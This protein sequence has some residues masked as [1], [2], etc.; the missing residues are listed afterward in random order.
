MAAVTLADGRVVAMTALRLGDEVVSAPGGATSPI[1]LFSH[2]VVGGEHDFVRVAAEP[3]AAGAGGR[4]LTLSPGH[5]VYAV[6]AG[7]VA[8]TAA[9]RL[10][11]AAALVVGDTLRDA[12][13]DALAVT[14]VTPVRGVGLYNPHTVSGDLIVDG[15]HVS[16]LTTAVAPAVARSLLAPLAWAWRVGVSRSGLGG[17][18]HASV[19]AAVLALLPTGESHVEL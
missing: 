11:A 16:T 6:P 7:G 8:T 9:P 5:Y 13:G 18:L 12:A 4:T 19:P 3:V 2:R 15:V 17:A 14:S 1:M 10:V